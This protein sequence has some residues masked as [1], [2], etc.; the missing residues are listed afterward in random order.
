MFALIA[1]I[2]FI[3]ALFGV[4]IGSIDLVTLGLVFV[5]LH[6]MFDWRP[7]TAIRVQRP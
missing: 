5:A 2:C 4:V 3:L 7:W 6:L 1:L